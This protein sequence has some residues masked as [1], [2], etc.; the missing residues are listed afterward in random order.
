M[1]QTKKGM[2]RFY[3]PGTHCGGY[4]SIFRASIFSIF[5]QVPGIYKGKE[6]LQHELKFTCRRCLLVDD[7]MGPTR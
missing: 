6:P 7:N 5:F 1:A 4:A 2:G 3:V